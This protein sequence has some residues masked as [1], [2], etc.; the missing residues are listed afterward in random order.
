M[1]G[2]AWKI[3]TDATLTGAPP[4]A[5]DGEAAEGVQTRTRGLYSYPEICGMILSQVN[6]DLKGE[7]APLKKVVD[8]TKRYGTYAFR[9]P[10]ENG[11]NGIWV[12]FEEPESAGS[13]A[14]FVRG[15]GL[16]GVAVFDLSLED[17]R[18]ACSGAKFPIVTKI[19]EKLN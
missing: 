3:E 9:L 13:K 5:A 2:R 1:F 18:G 4:V 17:F 19:K 6:K 15:K 10:D 14:S 11:S 12:G 16:G 8:P 7:H